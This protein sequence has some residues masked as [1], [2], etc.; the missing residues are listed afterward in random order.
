M[1]FLDSLTKALAA[2][3]VEGGATAGSIRC[4]GG[5]QAYQQLVDSSDIVDAVYIPLPSALHKDWVSKTLEAGK[6]VLLEKPVA[7]SAADFEAMTTTAHRC[8]KLLM[9]GT[10]FVHTNR[11]WKLLEHCQNEEHVGK[12]Q[13]IEGAFSFMGTE[14][15]PDFFKTNIR[16]QKDAEPLG[17]MGDLGWYCVYM[18]LLIFNASASARPVAARVVDF[19]CTPDGVPIDASCVVYFEKVRLKLNSLRSASGK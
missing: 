5:P 16:C 1:R 19:E 4:L 6:H 8:G 13:R 17:C 9:D 11:T 18:A 7:L 3:L 2:K 14:S 12:I 10:M 15:S